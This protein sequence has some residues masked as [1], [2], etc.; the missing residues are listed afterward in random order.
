[1]CVCVFHLKFCSTIEVSNYVALLYKN[2][3]MFCYLIVSGCMRLFTFILPTMILQPVKILWFCSCPTLNIPIFQRVTFPEN[4]PTTH[5]ESPYEFS[6]PRRGLLGGRAV[7]VQRDWR[8]GGVAAGAGTATKGAGAAAIGADTWAVNTWLHLVKAICRLII[9]GLYIG[10]YIYIYTRRIKTWGQ[11]CKIRE[12]NDK[13]SVVGFHGMI[14]R[15]SPREQMASVS[16][17]PRLRRNL[18]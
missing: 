1:M 11:S 2:R 5:R 12:S 10:D 9:I 18:L 13:P 3:T 7:F 4:P 16:V 6:A 14:F 8:P 17:R 15:W